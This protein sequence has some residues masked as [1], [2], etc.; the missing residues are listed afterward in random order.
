MPSKSVKQQRFM[1]MVHAYQKGELKN[2]SP[3]VK[4]TAK[5]MKY[6]DAEHFAS[7]KHK[8]LPE[9]V[10]KKKSKKKYESAITFTEYL[11]KDLMVNEEIQ[12]KDL[13]KCEDCG[14]VGDRF[15]DFSRPF[16]KDKCPKCK[17]KNIQ[18]NYIPPKPGIERIPKLTT[19]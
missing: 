3:E 12:V 8:G 4:K 11:T 1:G 15:L 2:A 5:S 6:D 16:L 10:R 17:S 14:Y 18:R 9:K 19:R 13:A 7:T